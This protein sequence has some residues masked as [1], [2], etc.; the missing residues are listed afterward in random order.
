MKDQ[1]KQIPLSKS[2]DL[3]P[4]KK[5]KFQHSNGRSLKRERQAAV[6]RKL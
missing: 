4:A 6:G 5:G 1:M 3:M 2:Q